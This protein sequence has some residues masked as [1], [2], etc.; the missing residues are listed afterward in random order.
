MHTDEWTAW[1]KKYGDRIDRLQAGLKGMQAI[2]DRFD[3]T[4]RHGLPEAYLL[5]F[6]PKKDGR[7]IIATGNPDKADHTAVYVPGTGSDLSGIHGSLER[8]KNLWQAAAPLAHGQSV[9]TIAWLGYDAPDDVLKDATFSHYANDGA[10]AFNR[11]VDGL[12]AS[13]EPGSAGHTTVVGHSYGTTLIGSAARQGDL[14]ADDVVFAGSPGVQVDSAEAMDV[15][16]GHVWNEEAGSD[17]V[18]ELGREFHSGN[19]WEIKDGRIIMRAIG[20][21]PSDEE[22]GA[23]QMRTNTSGHSEYWKEDS[24]SLLNQARVIAGRYDRV[25]HAE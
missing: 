12:H 21:I 8:T 13:H 7:A 11:F 3:E 17:S 24:D 5:G 4:G 22:F 16:K 14:H 15:P 18:P 19:Q 10:P 1:H 6:D 25:T 23:V 9:S 20:V 2:R